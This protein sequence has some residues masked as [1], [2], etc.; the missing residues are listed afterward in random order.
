VSTSGEEIGRTSS[1]AREPSTT[2]KFFFWVRPNIRINPFD[3]VAV[4]LDDGSSIV[5]QV[6]EI[7]NYTDAES[8]LGN[9]IGSSLEGPSRIERL[10]AVIVEATV[11]A[12]LRKDG[13]AELLMPVP[14][15][16]PVRFANDEEVSKALGYD[17]VLGERIPA[18]LIEQSN[19]KEYVVYLDSHYIIG[20]EGAHV[21]ITGISGLA[22]KT[23]YAMFL[24]NSIYQKLGGDLAV[25]I[26]NVKHSDL[27]HI[28]EDPDDLT[29]SDH[30][31]YIKLNLN[32]E[33]F[34]SGKV[35]YYLPRGKAGEP[36]SDNP[37][38][39]HELYA[40]TLRDAHENLDLLLAD[41]PD[42]NGT[43]GAFTSYV[44]DKWEDD[45]IKFGKETASNWDDLL[46]ISDAAISSAV[47]NTSWH[48]TPPRVKR[49]IRRRKD[50]AGIF[51]DGRGVDSRGSK[52][53]YLGERIVED[54]KERKIS[55]IDIY[56][57]HTIVQPFIVG[58][59]MRSIE[60]GYRNGEFEGLKGLIIFID[61]LNTFAPDSSSPNAIAEDIIEIARKG[62]GRRT[63]LFGVQ[64]F[65]SQVH[66]QVWGNCSLHV[67]GKVG[68]AELSTTSYR[69]LS[70]HAKNT[71]MGLRQGEVLLSFSTWR[72]P[73]KVVF[74]KPA[75]KRFK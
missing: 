46:K 68:S 50:S 53:V 54:I 27:L 52:E 23:S 63:A 1:T 13:A 10:Q 25:V 28:D 67:I 64:Q 39:K 17:R 58:D 11:L 57:I 5:G 74:P 72:S 18:G 62:R 37:P 33:P 12:N 22:T 60:N 7:S 75:Y 20:P 71:V 29:E 40:Y 3:F 45:K 8:H 48:Q 73:I 21:N 4:Q 51:V 36:D 38:Q 30:D 56:R 66:P 16:R 61:E 34:P 2:E 6:D 49:E 69:E 43:I 55:V 9:Y 65:K 47:Y 70:Q 31:M 35:T 19:G 41:V 26:F 14:S 44:R 59:V 15:D 42:P 24:I 32:P